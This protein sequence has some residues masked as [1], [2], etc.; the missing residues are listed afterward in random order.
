MAYIHTLGDGRSLYLDNQGNQTTVTLA[1]TGVGQQQQSSYGF[2]TGSW[3]QPPEVAQS[4][5]GIVIKLTTT[6][7]ESFIQVQGSSVSLS[8]KSSSASSFQAMQ[9]TT[10]SE[11]MQPMQPMQPMKMGDMQMNLNPMEMRMGNMELR[12]ENKPDES[13]TTTATRRFCS[14]CGVAVK[15]GDRFC[16]SCGSSLS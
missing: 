2:Q 13:K 1:S 8:S 5:V 7:G 14:Q 6:E 16:S 15:P 9:T 4:T 3:T 12:M 10:S 11:T